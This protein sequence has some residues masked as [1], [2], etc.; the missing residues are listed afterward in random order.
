GYHGPKSRGNNLVPRHV[1]HSQ[2]HDTRNAG[3]S[4]YIPDSPPTRNQESAADFCDQVLSGSQL[5]F[6]R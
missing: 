6:Y 4:D 2:I 5:P 1:F 3:H